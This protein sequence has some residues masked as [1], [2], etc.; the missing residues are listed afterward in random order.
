MPRLKN[1]R[2]GV[3]VNVDSE[4]AATLKA[5]L[6]SWEPVDSEKKAPPAK[7]AASKKSDD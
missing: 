3:V 6:D 2:T 4:T 1:A 5:G 7:K